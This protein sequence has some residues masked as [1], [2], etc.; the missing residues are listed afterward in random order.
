M[1]VASESF[2]KIARLLKYSV[3]LSDSTVHFVPLNPTLRYSRI[4]S[5]TLI[6]GSTNGEGLEGL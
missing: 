3:R 6:S 1:F 4:L 2:N 5:R